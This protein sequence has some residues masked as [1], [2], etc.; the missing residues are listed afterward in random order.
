MGCFWGEGGA[1]LGYFN[2][3]IFLQATVPLP[4]FSLG[5]RKNEQLDLKAIQKSKYRFPLGYV[6]LLIITHDQMEFV[7]MQA[8][9][10]IY[11][12]EGK[13]SSLKIAGLQN[14]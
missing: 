3:L 9:P 7:F 2:V 8:V 12:Y 11:F 10:G 6:A 13:N 1:C 14:C 5:S 4:R